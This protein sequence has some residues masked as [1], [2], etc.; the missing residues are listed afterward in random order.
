[1]EERLHGPV[2]KTAPTEALGLGEI[3]ALMGEF[4]L[5]LL[6]V[7]V[8]GAAIALAVDVPAAFIQIDDPAIAA[9][10]TA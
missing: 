4:S 10:F 8:V 7:L 1:M 9:N 5:V 3:V 6:A 2:P